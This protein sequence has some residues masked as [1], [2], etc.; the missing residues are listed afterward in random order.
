MTGHRSRLNWNLKIHESFQK[1]G[2]SCAKNCGAN[3]QSTKKFDH[4]IISAVARPVNKL[5][6][7]ARKACV[8]IRTRKIK[9]HLVSSSTVSSTFVFKFF[10]LTAKAGNN[11][12]AKAKLKS[13]KSEKIKKNRKN[14]N[15]ITTR[16]NRADKDP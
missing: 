6:K 2:E 14:Q 5:L 10:F 4:L 15:S 9:L 12:F 7:N 13:R 3:I 8:V 16:V 11:T 1:M